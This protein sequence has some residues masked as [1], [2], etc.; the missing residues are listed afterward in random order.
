MRG[1]SQEIETL[2]NEEALKSIETQE[3]KPLFEEIKSPQR[4]ILDEIVLCKILG[5]KKTE[6]IEICNS[7]GELFRQRIERFSKKESAG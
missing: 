7:A 2:I 1:E 6:M 3:V 4:Q 5:L